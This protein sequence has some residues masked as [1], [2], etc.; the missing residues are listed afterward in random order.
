MCPGRTR[1]RRHIR[2]IRLQLLLLL[3]LDWRF[4][5]QRVQAG[6]LTGGGPRADLCTSL[7]CWSLSKHDSTV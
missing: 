5:G 6:S 2:S 7:C 4:E 3:L 1:R